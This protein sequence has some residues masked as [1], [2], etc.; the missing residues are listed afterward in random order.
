MSKQISISHHTCLR[1]GDRISNISKEESSKE[2]DITKDK[3]GKAFE[4]VDLTPPDNLLISW[5]KAHGE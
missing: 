3:A 4:E 5:C 1:F 2:L